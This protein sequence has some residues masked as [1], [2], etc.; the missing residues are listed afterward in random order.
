MICANPDRIVMRGEDCVPCAGA[1]A[2]AYQKMEGTV[3]FFGKPHP[4]TYARAAQIF[5]EMGVPNI[6]RVLAIGDGLET[7]MLGALHAELDMIF[8][9]S[10]IHAR[11]LG[12]HPS[13]RALAA[14]FQKANLPR[15]PNHVMP[16]LFW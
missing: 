14:L 12:Q 4:P 11:E 1:L 9:S 6:K 2:E 15:Q 10:G 13:A 16:H 5:R 7:D 8:I 3:L